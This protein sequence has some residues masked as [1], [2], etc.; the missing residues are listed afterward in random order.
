MKSK[1]SEIV[2]GLHSMKDINKTRTQ[3]GLPP[4]KLKIR[5]CLKCE[6]KF[7]SHGSHNRLCPTHTSNSGEINGYLF[8]DGPATIKVS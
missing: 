7:T 5:Q 4:L 6:K 1:S 8:K 2:I 3:I